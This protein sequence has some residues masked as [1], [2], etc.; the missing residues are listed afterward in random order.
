MEFSWAVEGVQ[1]VCVCK[2]SVCF[3]P[4]LPNQNF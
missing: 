3:T 4:L 1:G 2:T